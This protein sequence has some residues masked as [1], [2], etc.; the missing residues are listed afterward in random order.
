MANENDFS[1]DIERDLSTIGKE[2]LV[3]EIYKKM[4]ELRKNPKLSD[5]R[6]WVWEL[7]QNANDARGLYFTP[8]QFVNS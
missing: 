5:M 6:R 7:I 2:G 4:G 8:P 3:K 1:Q